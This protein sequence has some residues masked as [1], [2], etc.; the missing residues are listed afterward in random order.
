MHPGIWAY[1]KNHWNGQY[2]FS[3]SFWV[4]LVLIIAIFQ[5]TLYFVQKLVA[6]NAGYHQITAYIVLIVCLFIIF[7]LVYIWSIVG[8]VRATLKY[9]DTI[10]RFFTNGFLFIALTLLTIILFLQATL[11][12]NTGWH[13]LQVTLGNDPITRSGFLLKINKTT[14]KVSGSISFGLPEKIKKTLLNNPEITAVEL[15][16]TGGYLIPAHQIIKIILQHKLNTHISKSCFSACPLIFLAG[17]KRTI[18]TSAKLGF[19]QPSPISIPKLF[20]ISDFPEE[21]QFMK[22]RNI[23]D[24]FIETAFGTPKTTLWFPTHKELI[25]AGYITHIIEKTDK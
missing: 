22:S 12:I 16:S 10:L 17:K 25:I 24:S 20:G 8:T 6:I 2:S 18:T 13:L 9:P 4:H 19:H 21:H 7:L 23:P 15:D 5:I 3:R 1:L 14:L 11:H